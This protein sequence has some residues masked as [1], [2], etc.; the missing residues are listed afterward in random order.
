M[1]SAVTAARSWADRKAQRPGPVTG[2]TLAPEGDG[3]STEGRD[4]GGDGVRGEDGRRPRGRGMQVRAGEGDVD[5]LLGSKLYPTVSYGVGQA[6]HTEE[7]EDPSVQ[8]M[9]RIRD[10]DDTLAGLI[11][12]RGIRM[13]G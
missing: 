13:V 4:Q 2:G 7:L 1:I 6:E 5:R 8:G 9:R 3:Q 10:R 11:A 12:Y